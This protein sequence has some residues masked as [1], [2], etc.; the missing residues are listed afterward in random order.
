MSDFYGQSLKFVL[1]MQKS[2]RVTKNKEIL[3]LIGIIYSYVFAELFEVAKT[4]KISNHK[5]RETLIL[6]LGTLSAKTS[7]ARV[8]FYHFDYALQ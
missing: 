2:S 7:D 5:V 1:Q 4:Q 8:N 6:T 3:I